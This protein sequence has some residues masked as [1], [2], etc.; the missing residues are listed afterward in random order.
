MTI[1]T[2]YLEPSHST[3]TYPQ[4][5][6]TLTA[7]W[8]ALV[9]WMLS[10]SAQV[11][12]GVISQGLVEFERWIETTITVLDAIAGGV[13]DTAMMLPAILIE[14]IVRNLLDFLVVI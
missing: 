9:L 1:S 14:S 13:G 10:S 4:Q 7:F 8:S 11:E 6:S 2:F 5:K 12:I 3:I